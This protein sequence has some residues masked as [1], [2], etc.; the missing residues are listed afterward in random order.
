MSA[1]LFDATACLRFDPWSGDY[2]AY[3]VMSDKIVVAAKPHTGCHVCDGGIKQGERH[4]VLVEI[5]EGEGLQ[6]YRFCGE[7]CAAMAQSDDDE[8]RAIESRTMLHPS[9]AQYRTGTKHPDGT[10][11][12]S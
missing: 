7:C 8:G 11:G 10:E 5:V 2:T 9:M 12:Q 4:R 3:R 6:T 1:P